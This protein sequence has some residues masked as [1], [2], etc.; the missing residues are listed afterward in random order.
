MEDK[1]NPHHID[2][3]SLTTEVAVDATTEACLASAALAAL[4]MSLPSSM[5]DP[6]IQSP[7]VECRPDTSALMTS[8]PA[9]ALMGRPRTLPGQLQATLGTG[10]NNSSSGGGSDSSSPRASGCR[11]DSLSIGTCVSLAVEDPGGEET[12]LRAP[13]VGYE[14]MEQRAKFT[15]FKIHVQKS[16]QEHWLLFRRYTDFVRV[17]NKLRE[18]FPIFRLALPPKRWF[19]SNFDLNFLE[20][21]QLGLQAFIDNIISHKD[22]VL[23]GPVREFLCLDDPPGPH[24]NLEESR[25]LCESLDET[26]YSLRLELAERDRQIAALN[27][28]VEACEERIRHLLNSQLENGND[29]S[30][31]E[32]SSSPVSADRLTI[33]VDLHSQA[34]A[35]QSLSFPQTEAQHSSL[36]GPDAEVS[37]GS[38]SANDTESEPSLTPHKGTSFKQGSIT[39]DGEIRS[40]TESSVI[41]VT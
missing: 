26:V 1:L 12:N 4:S 31:A 5:N 22:I 18:I 30:K 10:G 36:H 40:H 29:R 2:S 15:V 25:A 19:G 6:E 35:D 24:D 11:A 32:N 28:K 23:S 27:T 34:E 39:E 3:T 33:E 20:D 7:G 8:T 21:R 17:N 38:A 41:T 14:I 37:G 13:I 16:D 9:G